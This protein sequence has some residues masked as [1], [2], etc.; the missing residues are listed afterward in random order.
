MPP[1][2]TTSPSN[3]KNVSSPSKSPENPVDDFFLFIDK[4]CAQGGFRR[5]KGLCQENE[6]LK[7]KINQLNTAYDQNIQALTRSENKWQSENGRCEEANRAKEAAEKDLKDEKAISQKLNNQVQ[8]LDKDVKRAIA[9]TKAKEVQIGQLTNIERSQADNLENAQRERTRLEGELRSK[10]E[11]LTSKTTELD[12]VQENL[13]V[14]RSFV[15]DLASLADKKVIMRDLL[16]NFFH[17]ALK[18]MEAFMYNDLD[19]ACLTNTLAWKKTRMQVSSQ[20]QIPLPASNSTFAKQMRVVAGLVIFGKALAKHI[21]RSTYITLGGELDDVLS[22][23]DTQNSLHEMYLRAVVL[24]VLPETQRK[25]QGIAVKSVVADV[26]DALS[27]LVPPSQQGEFDSRL[28][29]VSDEICHDWLQVQQLQERVRPS[30][31]FDF[32]A[33]WQPLPPP[34]A[35]LASTPSS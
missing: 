24:K 15:I 14:I 33:E 9:T 26:S 4:Y 31:S 28:K 32:P 23:L 29:Q 12:R 13:K 10:R 20:Q 6:D 7:A 25:N 21:F 30:F 19:D 11:Q 18:H 34:F 5:L 35:Q 8:A 2:A 16:A 27:V 1:T 3:P 17:I 22:D